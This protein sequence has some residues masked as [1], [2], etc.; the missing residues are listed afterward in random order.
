MADTKPTEDG[1]EK[2]YAAAVEGVKSDSPAP[3]KA[4]PAK[5]APVKKAPVKKAPAKTAAAKP[6]AAKAAPVKKAPV[7]KAPVAKAAP[8]PAAKAPVAK[9]P[10][11]QK[12]VAQKPVAKKP[13]AAAKKPV[14]KKPVAKAPAAAAPKIKTTPPVIEMKDKIMATTDFAASMTESMSDAVAEMQS[15]LQEAYDKGTGMVTEMTEFA[16]GNVDAMVESGKIMA[17]G[18]QDM[19]QGAADEAKSAYETITADLKEMAAVKSPTELFQLQGK[20]MRRNFDAMVAAS[21]KNTD[22]AIKLANDVVAPISGR[23]NMAAEKL[24]KVA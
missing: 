10:V 24:S 11:A 7:K 6:A 13:V 3:A 16:K 14:A 9:K 20:I 22:A 23:V 5:K 12:P 8:K 15:K 2:A 19:G 1:A 4:A 17:S 21:S 18:V